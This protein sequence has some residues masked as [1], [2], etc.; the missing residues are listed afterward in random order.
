MSLFGGVGV[1]GGVAC[2]E[3]KKVERYATVLEW[4]KTRYLCLVVDGNHVLLWVREETVGQH[5]EKLNARK[6]ELTKNRQANK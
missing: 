4:N 2:V 5:V 1:E 6:I 3:G